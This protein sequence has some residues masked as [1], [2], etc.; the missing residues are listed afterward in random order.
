[1]NIGLL[2]KEKRLMLGLTLEEVGTFVGVGKSTVRKWENGM[3]E[4]MGR[5]KIASLSKI[6]D[7]D[8]ITLLGLEKEDKYEEHLKNKPELLE[9]Y[10]NIVDNDRLV[11]LYDKTKDLTPEDMEQVLKIID[12]FNKE[13]MWSKWVLKIYFVGITSYYGMRTFQLTLEGLHFTMVT[14][15]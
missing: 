2:I 11:L 3:I 14:V 13:T 6:L 7:I 4:N 1:M 5:D 8:P 10:K 12:T 9:L 15:I